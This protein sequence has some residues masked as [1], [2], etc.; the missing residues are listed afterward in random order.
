MTTV[1]IQLVAP[2]RSSPFLPDPGP[3]FLDGPRPEA[4]PS[5]LT[6]LLARPDLVADRMLDAR[7]HGGLVLASLLCIGVSCGFFGAVAMSRFGPDRMA[8]SALLCGADVL[9]ALAAAL[10]PIYAAGVLLAARVPMA[11]LVS[12]LVSSAASGCLILG[13]LAPLPHAGW[14]LDV[15]T[16]GP[17]STFGCFLVAAIVTGVRLHALLVRLAARMRLVPASADAPRR[18]GI[19]ARSALLIV[20]F[21]NALAFCGYDAFA[22]R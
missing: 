15:G 11:Q 17:C 2:E 7:R 21:T 6:E 3:P 10:G 12:V 19:L 22:P 8:R 9:I 20:A 14:A 13:A 16:W 5:I 4:A 1:S 18:I